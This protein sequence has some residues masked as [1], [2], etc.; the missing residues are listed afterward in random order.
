MIAHDLPLTVRRP[1]PIN[2]H[3]EAKL[4][5]SFFTFGEWANGIYVPQETPNPDQYEPGESGNNLKEAA[6]ISFG[7]ALYVEQ[8]SMTASCDNILLSNAIDFDFN[9]LGLSFSMYTLNSKEQLTLHPI[10]LGDFTHHLPINGALR[11]MGA[12]NSHDRNRKS[13]TMMCRIAGRI[14]QIKEFQDL[15]Y[16]SISVNVLL[17]AYDILSQEWIDIN[18]GESKDFTRKLLMLDDQYRFQK[19]LIN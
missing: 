15:E 8:M 5:S 6:N 12:S 11:A 16:K 1:H 17:T 7:Q 18:F 3:F 2:I 10:G 4:D 13:E 19:N 9:P 14:K